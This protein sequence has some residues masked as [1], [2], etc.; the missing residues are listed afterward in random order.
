MH[1]DYLLRLARNIR[2]SDEYRRDNPAIQE[3]YTSLKN[4]GLIYGL[5]MFFNDG[6]GTIRVYMGCKRLETFR[7]L[8]EDGVDVPNIENWLIPVIWDRKMT[9]EEAVALT[10]VENLVRSQPDY[11]EQGR[12]INIWLVGEKERY[13]NVG[14]R[15]LL[16]RLSELM[17]GAPGASTLQDTVKFFRQVE[18]VGE[19][20]SGTTEEDRDR[21]KKSKRKHTYPIFRLKKIHPRIGVILSDIASKRNSLSV[22]VQAICKEIQILYPDVK[23]QPSVLDEKALEAMFNAYEK[24]EMHDICISREDWEKLQ[25]RAA[26]GKLKKLTQIFAGEVIHDYLADNRGP[27]GS[28]N[29]AQLSGRPKEATTRR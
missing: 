12:G 24:K 7:Y 11:H 8:K 22:T 19:K 21:V 16:N 25:K 29:N 14:E 28:E 27:E 13:P 15:K 26:K 10:Y 6:D 2:A 20:G 4:K 3:L 9:E 23:E 18:A 5:K 17:G 1:L